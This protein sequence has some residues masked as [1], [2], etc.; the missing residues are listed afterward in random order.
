MSLFYLNKSEEMTDKMYT[1]TNHC[2]Q[3]EKTDTVWAR[4]QLDDIAG[5]MV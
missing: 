1:P 4:T 2:K 3:I 5:R